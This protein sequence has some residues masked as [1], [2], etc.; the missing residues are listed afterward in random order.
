MLGKLVFVFFREILWLDQAELK[1]S[2]RV[3]FQFLKQGPA[4]KKEGPDPNK[5][6]NQQ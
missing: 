5:G 6:S 4:N 1:T 3:F 2:G